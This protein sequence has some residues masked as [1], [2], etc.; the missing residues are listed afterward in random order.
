[1]GYSIRSC[2][3][4]YTEWVGFDPA[5]FRAHF[6]DVHAG[7]LYFV[8]TD[9]NQDKNLYNITEYAGVVQRFRSYLQK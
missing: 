5:T 9:P 7:E 8:A 1:M 2:D 6:Q 3:Y 4:R